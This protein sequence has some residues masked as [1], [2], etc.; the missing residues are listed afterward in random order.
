MKKKIN[1]NLENIDKVTS[2]GKALSSEIRI[3][4]L[5]YLIDKS[6]NITEISNYFNIPL[7]SAALHIKIL[8]EAN[9][10]ISQP[11]P[12]LRG[13][14]KLCGIAFEEVKLNIVD[15]IKR[16]SSVHCF[17]QNM[18]IGNF[19]DFD[20]KA[21]CGIVSDKSYIAPDDYPYGFNSEL[22]LKAQ[23]IWFT[24]GYL[25]YKFPN[26]IFKQSK[27]REMTFSFEICSE[28]VGYNNEWPSDVSIWLNDIEI[29]IIKCLGDYG[30]VRGIL[31]PEWWSDSL[32]Q[33]GLLHTVAVNDK[34]CYI[35]NI[36]VSEYN[37]NS[38]NLDDGYYINFKIGVK[39]D[40]KFVGGLNLFGEKFGNYNQNILLST[41]VD[42]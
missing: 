17:R 11:T 5:K 38:L 35:D 27:P 28:A 42:K 41:F 39:E 34:G 22:R 26:Q 14:Q 33:Y 31:N 32:T 21:P 16:H 25:V 18:P 10:I 37:L 3:E 20:I 2:V 1:L 23:L 36:K 29:G 30:D 4:I 13:S 9:M 7:S 8:E 12:G 19:F 24:Q 40:A 6:A 15:N